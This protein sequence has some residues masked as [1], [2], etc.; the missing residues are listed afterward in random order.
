MSFR[1]KIFPQASCSC[2]GCTCRWLLHILELH[3]NLAHLTPSCDSKLWFDAGIQIEQ[4]FAVL[5]L[6]NFSRT[7][8]ENVLE[9]LQV[10]PRS[11]Q[12][13]PRPSRAFHTRLSH[14]PFTW[15]S[16]PLRVMALWFWSQPCLPARS[17]Q[18]TGRL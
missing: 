8:E 17:R 14:A 1:R 7:I 9:Q 16:D 2:I 3:P 18:P 10:P 6:G 4:P 5:P 15:R 11:P 12:S 13:T